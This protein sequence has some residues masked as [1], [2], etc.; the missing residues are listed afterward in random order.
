MRDIC[1]FCSLGELHEPVLP[2]NMQD[3]PLDGLYQDVIYAGDFFY[4]KPD[5]SPIVDNHLLIIPMKHF[6]CMNDIPSESTEELTFIKRRLV[7][8]Y[9]NM[10]MNYVFFEHGSCGEG[11]S[12]SSC[13]NHAH[14]HAIPLSGEREK[15]LIEKIVT[16][17]GLPN[18]NQ[19]DIKGQAYL[20]FESTSIKKPQFWI[21]DIQRHQFFRIVIAEIT[22]RIQRS[23][24]QNC[25][26]NERERDIS[27]IWL[28]KFKPEE[29]KP[30]F[31]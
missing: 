31:D 21:D 7:D 26:I 20:Y 12:G 10:G 15:L 24:W 2:N 30:I 25:L 9:E 23:R 17:L 28:N 27:K 14:L 8:Y 1:E 18:A 3:I 19:I 22:G 4:V 6:L 5:I 13:I 11:E 29:L 16:V